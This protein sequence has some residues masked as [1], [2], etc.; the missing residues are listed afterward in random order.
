MHKG[1]AAPFVGGAAARGVSAVFAGAA[2]VAAWGGPAPPRLAPG[3]GNGKGGD[4]IPCCRRLIP[5][6]CCAR[7]T[8][9]GAPAARPALEHMAVVKKS[10]EHRA[11]SRGVAQ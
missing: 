6:S 9:F 10:V 1:G 4:Q 7:G 8:R 2:R 5:V 3:G 11:D